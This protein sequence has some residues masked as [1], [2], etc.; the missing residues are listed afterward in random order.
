MGIERGGERMI[1]LGLGIGAIVGLI[2]GFVACLCIMWMFAKT[3]G[4]IDNN[5]EHYY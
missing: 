2:G 1:W 3:N 4:D 5:D